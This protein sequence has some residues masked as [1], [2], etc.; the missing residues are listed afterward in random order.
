VTVG[1]IL[2]M[3]AHLEGRGVGMIEMAGLAQK[4]GAVHIHARIAERPEDIG[5]IRVSLAEADALIGGDLVVSAGARTLGL[6]AA[7]RT[8]A[9]VNS[10]E[11][12]TGAFTR[13]PGFRLP[14]QGLRGALAARLGA[15][16]AFVDATAL[17]RATLGDTIFANMVVFGAAWQR[18]LIPLGLAAIRRAVELNG[19]AVA[20]NLR[21]FEIGR[22][23]ALHPTDAAALLAPTAAPEPAPAADPEAALRIR[24]RHLRDYG[25]EGLVRRFRALVDRAPDPALR[26]AIALGYHKLLAVKDEYEVARLH[27]QT[28]DRARAEFEGD[29]RP[30]F[31]LAP[32]FLPGRDTAGRPK[33][34]AFGPWVIVAFRALAALRGLRGGPLDPFRWSAERRMERALIARYEADMAEV[35]AAFTPDRRAAALALA[36]LPLEI[37]GFGP[38]KAANAEKAEARRA[39]LLAAFRAGSG[40]RALAAE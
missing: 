21:A 26:A 11:G 37:R 9:V 14:G 12:V 22:W 23:A 29:L 5:A 3:A 40:P 16:V 31:H 27:L 24:E 8:G 20:G 34:R 1:A 17:A 25:G 33:K 39:A 28:L 2:A 32:P 36:D 15:G 18:G 6:T 19:A 35:I 30:T 10:H 38:V 13:D 7:G 4:G